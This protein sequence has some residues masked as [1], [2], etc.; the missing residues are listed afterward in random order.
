MV[1]VVSVDLGV[2]GQ[3][4]VAVFCKGRELV[5]SGVDHHGREPG[6]LLC[7]GIC[8]VLAVGYAAGEDDGVYLAVYQ[9]ALGPLK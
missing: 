7:N 3:D 1:F 2:S 6:D 5:L 9:G 4:Y 8:D